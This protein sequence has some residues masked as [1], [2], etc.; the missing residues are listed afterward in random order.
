MNVNRKAF[1]AALTLSIAVSSS[2]LA[3]AVDVADA[4]EQLESAAGESLRDY[5]ALQQ[6]EAD[7]LEALELNP[8]NA[9]LAATLVLI[10]Q[11][12]EEVHGNL[13][14]ISKAYT[15]VTDDPVA[16]QNLYYGLA[17]VV[18]VTAAAAGTTAVVYRDSLKSWVKSFGKNQPKARE[19]ALKDFGVGDQK[20]LQGDKKL[21]SLI[22]AQ[23]STMLKDLLPNVE[24]DKQSDVLKRVA[25][26]LAAGNTVLSSDDLKAAAKAAKVVV[27][28][29][30]K[31]LKGEAKEGALAT[32]SLLDD[33]LA[34]TG[35]ANVTLGKDK[36][37]KVQL[38]AGFQHEADEKQKAAD[39]KKKAADKEAKEAKDKDKRD[40]KDEAVVNKDE[41]KEDGEKSGE[42][43]DGEGSAVKSDKEDSGSKS[44]E[45]SEGEESA[46]K[47]DKE[48]DAGSKSGE[49]S[50][51]EGSAAV[52]SD[53]EEGSGSKSSEESEGEGSAVKS[54]KEEGAGEGDRE[55][56][57]RSTVINNEDG[58][59][60][61][62]VVR[63]KI[64][65]KARVAS[66]KEEEVVETKKEDK[67]SVVEKT[68]EKKDDGATKEVKKEGGKGEEKAKAATEKKEVG[69]GGGKEKAK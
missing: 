64:K 38:T 34:K 36:S 27:E 2:A 48:G 45:K 17:S 42:K 10:K 57:T 23:E 32:I 11:R 54:D 41:K 16:M 9:E 6:L 58:Q 26:G 40:K 3:V 29:E 67:E 12:R 46:V 14:T 43:S 5:R 37:C 22:G 62:P 30:S 49:E 1:L 50:E 18:L 60:K 31:D 55:N 52:E 15:R 59:S 19:L 24:K 21:H 20:I 65:K 28:K 4:R 39:E 53:K 13:G 33:M 68:G 63:K 61:E 25:L 8:G 69:K 66:K 44:S 51:G 7:V 35:E 56:L 47:S